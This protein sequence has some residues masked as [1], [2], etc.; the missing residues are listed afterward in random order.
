[1]TICL[2]V[3]Q[4]MAL[5]VVLYRFD[6][7]ISKY[8]DFKRKIPEVCSFCLWRCGHKNVPSRGTVDWWSKVC[9]SD[10]RFGNFTALV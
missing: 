8:T 9:H 6:G 5:S 3:T 2:F 4:Y 1:M 7:N 10:D